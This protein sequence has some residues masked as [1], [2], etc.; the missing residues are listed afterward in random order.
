[1]TEPLEMKEYKYRVGH[2]ETTALLTEKMAERLNAVPSDQE[3]PEPGVGN[4]DNNEAQRTSTQTR[5]ADEAGVQATA[6]DGSTTEV[7]ST[8]ARAAR[9]KRA[10]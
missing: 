9:N 4:V 5:E 10:S 7:V 6:D 3:L 1:M 8:K 2:I